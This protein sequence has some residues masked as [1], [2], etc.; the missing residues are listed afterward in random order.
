MSR[1]TRPRTSIP[2]RARASSSLRPPRLTKGRGC[3]TSR[4]ASASMSSPGL[5]TG[6]PALV[7]DPAM[8]RAWA[9][10]RLGARPRPARSLSARSFTGLPRK[11]CSVKGLDLRDEAGDVEAEPR[12]DLF[13]LAVGVDPD[14]HAESQE[15][16]AEA[17]FAVEELAH[18]ARRA[19]LDDAFLDGDDRPPRTGEA[20][21]HVA[22]ERL[23]EAGVDDG[24]RDPALLE[25]PGRLEGRG[26]HVPDGEEQVPSVLEELGLAERQDLEPRIQGDAQSLGLGE[27]HG[28]RVPVR[29]GRPE[30]VL[31]LV[32][33]LG[34]HD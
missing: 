11:G 14:R 33:V 29:D 21:D 3:A 2:K 26:D 22:V 9:F 5:R 6:R 31:E 24:E 30:H 32:L 12:A 4:G 16:D 15:P 7:T 27:A 1:A 18:G 17:A 28:G 20:Q 25:L 13:R 10:S 23:D 34:G 19:A 8:I